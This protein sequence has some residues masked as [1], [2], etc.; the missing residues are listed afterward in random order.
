MLTAV[1]HKMAPAL[2]LIRSTDGDIDWVFTFT[3]FTD[4]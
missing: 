4:F 2:I 3:M 1:I